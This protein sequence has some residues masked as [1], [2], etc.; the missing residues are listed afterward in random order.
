MS[1]CVAV[2]TW[3]VIE[4]A[5]EPEASEPAQT[6]VVFNDSQFELERRMYH[7]RAT[8]TYILLGIFGVEVLIAFLGL[9]VTNNTQINGVLSIVFGPTVALVGSATGF[10]YGSRVPT[11]PANESNRKG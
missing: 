7:T 6:S 11:S 5:D 10:Y 8:M 4:V 1:Y 3:K 2:F 9:F